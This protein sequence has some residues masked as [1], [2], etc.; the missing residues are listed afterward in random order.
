ME[1][2]KEKLCISIPEM[3]K[4]LGIGKS[5]GYELSRTEGFPAFKVGDRVLISVPGLERWLEQQTGGG[6]M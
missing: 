6:G 4:R 1:N 5:L 2:K 3:A